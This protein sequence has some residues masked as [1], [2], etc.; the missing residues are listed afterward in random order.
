[1]GEEGGKRGGGSHG[2][3]EG[4]WNPRVPSSFIS[5]W[6]GS[7]LTLVSTMQSCISLA[8]NSRTPK[9]TQ[10]TRTKKDM[11]DGDNGEQK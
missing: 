1:M 8:F 11:D 3:T 7:S 6:H 10:E 2:R 4:F 9:H 5:P